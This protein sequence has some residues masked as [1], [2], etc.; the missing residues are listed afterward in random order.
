MGR[1]QRK[2]PPRGA[3]AKDRSGKIEKNGEN[4]ARARR[5]D[6]YKTPVSFSAGRGLLCPFIFPSTR[7]NKRDKGESAR[8]FVPTGPGCFIRDLI[9]LIT[10]ARA[11]V[12][13]GIR[14]CL[15]KASRSG[16]NVFGGIACGRGGTLGWS[17]AR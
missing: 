9:R 7:F 2:I 11:P 6:L 13:I 17:I 4:S 15:G 12:C 8:R 5:N 10:C 3:R 14:G 16:K 1:A